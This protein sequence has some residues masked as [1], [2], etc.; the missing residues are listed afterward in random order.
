MGIDPHSRDQWDIAIG[1][2]IMAKAHQWSIHV[3]RSKAGHGQ[4]HQLINGSVIVVV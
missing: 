4:Q 3:M 2:G 1:D